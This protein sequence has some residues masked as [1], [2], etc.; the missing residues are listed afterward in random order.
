MPLNYQNI[1]LTAPWWTKFGTQRA[2]LLLAARHPFWRH[3]PSTLNPTKNIQLIAPAPLELML[4]SC[5]EPLHPTVF[6]ESVPVKW[7]PLDVSPTKVASASSQAIPVSWVL[8]WNTISTKPSSLTSSTWP[9]WEGEKIPRNTRSTILL[10]PISGKLQ[11]LSKSLLGQQ[12]YGRN[13]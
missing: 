4:V 1:F 12:P 9:S 3:S 8:K 5:L 11:I 7:V 6:T 10:P 13:N 2:W